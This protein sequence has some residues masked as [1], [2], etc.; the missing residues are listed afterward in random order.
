MVD[1]LDAAKEKIR[2]LEH[3][4]V[5]LQQQLDWL[6]R[7]IFGAK[8]ERYVAPGCDTPL[9]PGFEP[10]AVPEPLATE[11]VEYDRR[12]HRNQSGWQEFPADLPR[13]EIVIELPETERFTADGRALELIGYDIIER[14]AQRSGYY[15]KVYKRAK[16]AVK[17]DPLQGVVTAAHPGDVLDGRSGKSKFDVSF[18]AHTVVSK[19]V[20][21]LPLYRQE[22]QLALRI[23]SRPFHN[24]TALCGNGG[25]ADAA[26]R[27]D[28]RADH[29]LRNHSCRRVVDAVDVTRQRQ[30]QNRLALVPDDRR[31][32]T[33]DRLCF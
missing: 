19:C 1:S 21:Y 28:G 18:I 22:Q 8:S 11:H 9:L 29:V 31:R 24:G 23:E 12:A 7:Q 20:D 14:L 33:P 2:S 10:A 30:V 6:K 13:E 32:T 26:L 3:T 15:I 5:Q 25:S 17:G 16:Y 4:V 27:T